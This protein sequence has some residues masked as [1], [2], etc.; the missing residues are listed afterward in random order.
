MLGPLA[1]AATRQRDVHGLG[2]DALLQRGLLE[3]LPARGERG[4]HGTTH[5]VG[6]LAHGRTILLGNRAHGAHD[7]RERALL[8][9]KRHAHPL[10]RVERACLHNALLRLCLNVP[11]VI[12]QCHEKP[13]PKKK[14]PLS[15]CPRTE[16]IRGTT[17]LGA[18][19]VSR[20][21][22]LLRPVPWDGRLPYLRRCALRS[23]CGWWSELLPSACVGASQPMD[24][25]SVRWRRDDR[26]SPS[27]PWSMVAQGTR[28][29]RR[30][31]RI[32]NARDVASGSP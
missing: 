16:T 5:A 19:V 4:L 28:G 8:A 26:T 27:L 17:L 18:R 29:A 11:E 7:G 25:R 24:P 1:E 31:Q 23:G 22:P 15:L 2:R 32:R 30:S 20:M 6:E 3:R 21:R 9:Q 12:G 10:E 14:P 13:L